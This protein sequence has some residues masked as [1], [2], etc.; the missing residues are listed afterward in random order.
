MPSW[1]VAPAI[2]VFKPAE[3][4]FG[5]GQRKRTNGMKINNGR[6]LFLTMLQIIMVMS[7]LPGAA[8][9][10]SVLLEWDPSTDADLAGYNVYYQA[11]SSVQPF[12]G[13]GAAAGSA[14]IDAANTTT[15]IID[16]LDP[17]NSYFFSVT[18][19]NSARLESVYSNIIQIPE[20][21]P[22]VVTITS[23]TNNASVNGTVSIS[24]T[25]S[26]NVAVA[27]VQFYLNE[28]LQAT[29]TMAPYLFTWDTSS[30]AAGAYTVSARASD[31]AGNLGRSEIVVTVAGDTSPPT[32]YLSA[33]G[34][35]ASVS[36]S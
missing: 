15:T 20:S 7:L 8:L 22:P 16:G 27:R 19:Y 26:D 11:N 30:L 4:F 25:A 9:A 28:V 35:N 1:V 12:K 21:A 17:A 13:T 18:A 24:A 6:M 14:P 3:P 31:S 36:G 34:N 10:A 23:P 32:V 29:D 5:A 2:F 33:P